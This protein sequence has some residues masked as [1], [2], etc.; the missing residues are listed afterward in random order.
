[1]CEPC[2][3]SGDKPGDENGIKYELGWA[4]DR[5]LACIDSV[6]ELPLTAGGEFT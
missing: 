1:M 3:D 6:S 2:L 5:A 4:K